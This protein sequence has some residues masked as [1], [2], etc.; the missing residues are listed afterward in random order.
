MHNRRDIMSQ[1]RTTELLESSLGKGGLIRLETT[2]A[3]TPDSGYVF[4]A[5]QGET[6]V[7][8][9]TTTGNDT[10]FDGAVIGTEGI[11][12]GR[13]TS[14]TLTSGTAILYQVPK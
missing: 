1:A 5:I 10:N 4:C 13:W 2:T 12:Y 9:N 3:T 8:V 14:I 7:V 11:R 6:D